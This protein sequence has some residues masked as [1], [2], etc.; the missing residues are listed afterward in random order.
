M[1]SLS[2]ENEVSF[3]TENCAMIDVVSVFNDPVWGDVD[4][5]KIDIEGAEEVVLNNLP[6]SALERLLCIAGEFHCHDEQFQIF[7]D[8]F[9][10]RCHGFGFKSYVLYQGYGL[11]TIHLWK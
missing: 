8:N 10:N 6:D 4:F 11:R 5:L 7:Q 1:Q 2:R 9:I 3:Y